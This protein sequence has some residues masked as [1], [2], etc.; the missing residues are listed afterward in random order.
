MMP[1]WLKIA[2]G[3]PENMTSISILRVCILF[4]RVIPLKDTPLSFKNIASIL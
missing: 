3:D 2:K 1:N 4:A